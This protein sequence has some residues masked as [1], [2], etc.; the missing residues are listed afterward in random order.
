MCKSKD[1]NLDIKHLSARATVTSHRLSL[2]PS[3]PNINARS[4][5]QQV[6]CMT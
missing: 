4:C 3:C 1:M 5:F 6:R 2:L